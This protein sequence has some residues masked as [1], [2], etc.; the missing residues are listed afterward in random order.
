MVG[1]NALHV[2]AKLGHFAILKALLTV[3]DVRA[4]Y[5]RKS[6]TP[7]ILVTP[8]SEIALEASE[9]LGA[10]N[11]ALRQRTGPFC[12]RRWPGLPFLDDAVAGVPEGWQESGTPS[13]EE[14]GET[15]AELLLRCWGVTEEQALVEGAKD[16]AELMNESMDKIFAQRVWG[17]CDD[18][19][20]NGDGLLTE[21]GGLR[22]GLGRV[23]SKS[24]SLKPMHAEYFL[25]DE[26]RAVLEE[27]GASAALGLVQFD[28]CFLQELDFQD[29]LGQVCSCACVVLLPCVSGTPIVDCSVLSWIDRPSFIYGCPYRQTH[30]TTMVKQHSIMMRA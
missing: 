10:N 17:L 20:S 24:S 28:A 9:N 22:T 1:F 21:V 19:D 6:T 16:A 7:K 18:F 12:R 8:C 14:G 11:G 15:F 2:A 30:W 26:L 13:K 23:W 29:T 4:P 5:L 25:Q 27:M 3:V